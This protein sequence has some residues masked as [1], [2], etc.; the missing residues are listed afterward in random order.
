MKSALRDYAIQRATFRL[1][2]LAIDPVHLLFSVD[3]VWIRLRMNSAPAAPAS[4][5]PKPT[6][7]FT[8]DK[9]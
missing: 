6:I 3:G 2:M 9:G 1:P 8:R 4:W 7:S 5:R